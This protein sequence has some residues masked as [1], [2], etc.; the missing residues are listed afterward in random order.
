LL[1]HHHLAENAKDVVRLGTGLIATMAALVLGLLIGSANTSFQTQSGQVTR[2]TADL[3]LLDQFLAQYGP[4]TRPVRDR[5]RHAVEPLIERIWREN[6]SSVT[7]Q[8]SFAASSEAET[9][10]AEIFA[11]PAQTEVQRALKTRAIDVTNDIARTRLLLFEQAG[12]SL[13]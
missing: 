1:P 3:I 2:V 6:R 12:D 9:A 13:P 5:L 4:E 10:F 11:L 8:A 7:A